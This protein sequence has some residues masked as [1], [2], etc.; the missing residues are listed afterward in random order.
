MGSTEL[1][2][3]VRLPLP[4]L[5][6][7]IVSHINSGWSFLKNII[8]VGNWYGLLQ[9]QQN[10]L[11]DILKGRNIYKFHNVDEGINVI[12][13]R[14]HSKRVLIVVDHVDNFSQ[15]EC[16]VGKHDWFCPGSRIIITTRNKHL[17]HVYGV[18]EK[19][20]S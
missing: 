6:V 3:L 19:L 17:L 14:S 13:D 10:L 11:N 16:I 7:I 12:K 20:R 8:E 18:G 9:L 15:L 1:V 4:K 2:A 5:F